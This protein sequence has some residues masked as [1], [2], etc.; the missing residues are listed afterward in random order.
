VGFLPN[1]TPLALALVRPSEVRDKIKDLSN[2]ANPARIV[3]I[4]L[5]WAVVV[6]AQASANDLKPA[7]A[8]DTVSKTLSRSLVDLAKRSRRVD[9]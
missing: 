3:I 1:L 8:L 6:S 4:N 5:P 9:E 7:P 2:S